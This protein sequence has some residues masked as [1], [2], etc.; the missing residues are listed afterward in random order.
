MHAV[1][2]EPLPPNERLLFAGESVVIGQVRCL[3]TDPL[4]RYCGRTRTYCAIF[5][6]SAVLI[7]RNNGR[8]F[9][10]DPTVVGLY[11]RG[12]EYERFKVSPEGDRGDWFAFAPIVIRD[13]IRAF[14]PAAADS[15][16]PLRVGW[17]RTSAATFL[18]QRLIFEHVRRMP[19]A[20]PI[21]VEEMCVRLLQAI[22]A[23]AYAG[24]RPSTDS[25]RAHE[26]AEAVRA[27]IDRRFALPLT[28]Q[29]IAA[30]VE[31]SVFHVCRVF[32]RVYG[33]SI[34]RYL[35]DVRL[36]RALEGVARPDVDLGQLALEVGFN[37]HSHF[38][39]AFRRE[40]GLVPSRYQSFRLTS[41]PSAIHALV[42]CLPEGT[43]SRSISSRAPSIS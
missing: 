40:F 28:L 43:T 37:S 2:N 3:P 15:A 4:F 5:P 33:T 25:S 42:K 36:R 29:S 23:E 27:I 39:A 8:P 12:E 7:R 22:V 35:T 38:T 18:Q 10:E 19:S 24:H 11:N 32:R 31:S 14:D 30:E 1:L 13:V 21:L 6:R 41:D 17:A 9:V 34:H 26:I 20:D 16:R